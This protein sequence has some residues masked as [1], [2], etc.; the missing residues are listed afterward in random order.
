MWYLWILDVC[1]VGSVVEDDA[2][3]LDSVVHP[4]AKLLLGDDRT[5]WVVRVAEVNH[6]HTMVWNLRSEAVALIAWHVS[7]VAP[8]AI[9]EDSRSAYHHVRVDIY[10]INRVG[11]TDVVVPSQNLLDISCVA[12]RSVVHE[13]LVRVE[14]DATRQEVVLDDGLTEEVVA[15]LRTVATE[16]GLHCHLIHCLV[17]CLDDGRAERLG[18]VADTQADNSLLRVGN[19]VGVH[20]LCDVGKQ[21]IVS[22]LQEMFIN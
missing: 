2:L 9:L 21:V 12:L 22:Q 7:H 17:H 8:L 4:L 11:D 13:Y 5:R 1:L 10:W 19:L 14:V 15:S 18:N 3:V 20:L 6:I 16:C